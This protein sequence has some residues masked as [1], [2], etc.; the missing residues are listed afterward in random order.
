LKVFRDISSVASFCFFQLLLLLFAKP[1]S[2]V[3]FLKFLSKLKMKSFIIILILG[4]VAK[5]IR[6]ESENLSNK[7]DLSRGFNRRIYDYKFS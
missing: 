6:S 3:F 1:T 2:L 4:Y 5:N 7:V